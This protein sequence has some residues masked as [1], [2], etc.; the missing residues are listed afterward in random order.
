MCWPLDTVSTAHRIAFEQGKQVVP[1]QQ[2]E[3]TGTCLLYYGRGELQSERCDNCAGSGRVVEG[4]EG[5]SY[6][7]LSRGM[8]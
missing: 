4:R 6:V 2:C 8:R 5:V 1:C 7:G 3:G